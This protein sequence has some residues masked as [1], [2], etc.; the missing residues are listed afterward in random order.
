MVTSTPNLELTEIQEVDSPAADDFN[1]T[2]Y[3]LD[4]IV[5]LSVLSRNTLVA[6]TDAVQGDRYIVPTSGLPSGSPWTGFARAIAFMS[7]E[8]W[9]F[10]RPRYGWTAIIK[11]ESALDASPPEITEVAYSGTEWV[12]AVSSSAAPGSIATLTF[13]TSTDET[14]I[15]PN[16]LR[17]LE[18]DN[19]D[20]DVSVPNELTIKVSGLA[21]VATSGDYADLTGT[22]TIPTDTF[23]KGAMWVN[24]S[25]AVTTPTNDVVVILPRACTLTEVDILTIGG[26]GS[27][28]IDIWKSTYSGFPPVIGGSICGGTPPAIASA[29]KYQNATLTGWT[30]SFAAGD[31]LLLHLSSSST[32]TEVGITLKFT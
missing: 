28:T 9:I 12:T 13:L 10:K 32:F 30:T 8:G 16:S 23:Q 4:G 6:P 25:G 15:A 1:A 27:C 14:H 3:S 21:D 19:I 29:A 11:D 5:Q 31:V 26:T 22:P 17:V 18:G 24:N 2:F 7:P 20:F